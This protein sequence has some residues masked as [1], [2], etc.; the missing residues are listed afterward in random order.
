MIAE[1]AGLGFFGNF[2]PVV[3]FGYHISN[4]NVV[5][6]LEVLQSMVLGL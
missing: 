4:S 1:G 6:G 5:S 2:L 3:V